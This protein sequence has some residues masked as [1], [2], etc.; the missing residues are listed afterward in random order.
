MFTR[1]RA[2]VSS[3]AIP[4]RYDHQSLPGAQS[5]RVSAFNG[6]SISLSIF[7]APRPRSCRADTDSLDRIFA[8]LFVFALLPLLLDPLP[9]FRRVIYDGAP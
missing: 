9:L 8:L 2:L 7:L 4:L 5:S 1:A 3:F 6:R